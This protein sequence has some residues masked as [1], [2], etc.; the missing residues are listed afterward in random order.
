MSAPA[1]GRFGRMPPPPPGKIWVRNPD[2]GWALSIV[3]GVERFKA[4]GEQVPDHLVELARSVPG[5]L[6]D[7]A[8]VAVDSDF[9]VPL[10]AFASAEPMGAAGSSEAEPDEQP[11]L[12][13]TEA[14]EGVDLE[15]WTVTELKNALDDLEVDYPANARKSELIALLEEAE[16]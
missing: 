7:T 10:P 2:T 6:P 9:G 15:G 13:D 3:A 14:S 5:E 16:Q 1:P 4:V 8:T 11:S 12:W